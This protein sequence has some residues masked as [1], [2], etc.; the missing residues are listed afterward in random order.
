MMN[1]IY[2]GLLLALVILFL[3]FTAYVLVAFIVDDSDE[4][5]MEQLRIPY[6]EQH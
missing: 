6:T 4:K 1:K 5:F 3:I 2:T